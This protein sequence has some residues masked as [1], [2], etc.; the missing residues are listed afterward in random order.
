MVSCKKLIAAVIVIAGLGVVAGFCY[1]D[2]QR[3]CDSTVP[4]LAYHR[5][6]PAKPDDTYTVPPETFEKQMAYLH[7]AGY[8]TI[9]LDQYVVA[10]KKGQQFHKNIVLIFDDGYLDNLT[11]AAPIM[12]K[13]GFTGSMYMAVKFEGWPGYIDWHQQYDLLK[14]GWEIGSHTFNHEPLPTLSEAALKDDLAK[15]KEYIMG[16]YNPPTGI[17]LSYPT[18]ATNAKVMKAVEEA[19]YIAAVSGNVGVNTDTTPFMAL[20]RV[21]IFN[22]RKMQKIEMF[23]LAIVKAQLKS[24]SASHGLDLV[25]IWDRLRGNAKS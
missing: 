10:R 14:Y 15:S 6:E 9:N 17:T 12:K 25:G 22:Y 7:A 4:V 5:V 8:K 16:I 2:F 18:G 11:V 13:Y 3:F 24:W 20:R 19:G 21:N 23:K 1:K